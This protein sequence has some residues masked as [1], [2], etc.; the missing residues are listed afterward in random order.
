[1]MAP[2]PKRCTVV[3][4]D[5]AMK[6]PLVQVDFEPKVWRL[7]G[8]A[9]H[10]HRQHK[11]RLASPATSLKPSCHHRRPGQ[12]GEASRS[13]HPQTSLGSNALESIPRIGTCR[14]GVSVDN[15][16]PM[17][18]AV[19]R[20]QPGDGRERA[21]T[22]NFLCH[23]SCGPHDLM[24]TAQHDRPP[25]QHQE[26]S[27]RPLPAPTHSTPAQQRASSARSS[28]LPFVEE[29]KK[30]PDG[31]SPESRVSRRPAG[32]CRCT[33]SCRTLCGDRWEVLRGTQA[34]ADCRHRQPEQPQVTGVNRCSAG[35]ISVATCRDSDA[36]VPLVLQLIHTATEPN[37]PEEWG[38]F[39]HAPGKKFT[40]FG[41]VRRE[42]SRRRRS[43][44]WAS[45]RRCSWS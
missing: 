44:R 22:V 32:C 24:H 9:T 28:V 5:A 13:Q 19:S 17:S 4:V 23:R 43:A 16:P 40:D 41:E 7:P 31:P 25:T 21:A 33:T 38:E 45:R 8:R 35:S 15:W 36:A 37:R 2:R 39:L 27:P 10:A 18:T 6:Q 14:N 11:S 30:K 1:M 20:H 3:Y 42:K 12:C 34:A 26:S 29:P